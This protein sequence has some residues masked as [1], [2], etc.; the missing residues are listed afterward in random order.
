MTSARRAIECAIASA[1]FATASGV[2]LFFAPMAGGDAWGF[3]LIVLQSCAGVSFAFA[4]AA[5]VAFR[6]ER[7]PP[8]RGFDVLPPR[9]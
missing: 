2:V 1:L 6:R 9:R 4:V 7:Q 3:V 8:E 5:L